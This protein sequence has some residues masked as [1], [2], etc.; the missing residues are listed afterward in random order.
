M[1]PAQTAMLCG[2][3]L[4]AAVGQFGITWA[5]RFAEP[6]Q[7]AAY[8]YAGVLF[9]AMFGF[10][11]FGQVPDMFSCAGFALVAVSGIVLRRR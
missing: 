2:A 7:V 11:L 8:D 6:R 10:A 1:T 4:A 5:Y 9:A 3:G